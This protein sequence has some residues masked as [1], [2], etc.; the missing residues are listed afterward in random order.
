M[1]AEPR[2]IPAHGQ[3]DKSRLERILLAERPTQGGGFRQREARVLPFAAPEGLSCPGETPEAAD[4]LQGKLKR[5]V[6][7][8]SPPECQ[9]SRRRRGGRTRPEEG[10]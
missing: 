1:S 7:P 10:K 4:K 9:Q 3:A 8:A 2:R 6:F 5:N